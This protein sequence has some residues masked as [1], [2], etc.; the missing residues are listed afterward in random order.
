MIK[1]KISGDSALWQKVIVN[2]TLEDIRYKH[3][4]G[5]CINSTQ[6]NANIHSIYA[7]INP[8]LRVFWVI[9]GENIN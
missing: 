4:I 3:E 6:D 9:E 5:I 1:N 7:F 2:K 8:N